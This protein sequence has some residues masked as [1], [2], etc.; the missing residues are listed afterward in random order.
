ML[1]ASQ[2]GWFLNELFLQGKLSKSGLKNEQMELTDF[3]HAGTN[4]RKLKGDWK[5][6]G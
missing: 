1:S 2:I 6:L 5:F 4:S 3:L